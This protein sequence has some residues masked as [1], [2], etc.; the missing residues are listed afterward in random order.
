MHEMSVAQNIVDIVQEHMPDGTE[1]GVRIVRLRIGKMAGIVTDS[2]EFCF[3]VITQGT[4]LQNAQLEI[5]TEPLV[6]RCNTCTRTS[7]IDEPIFLCPECGSAE[8]KV[9]SGMELHIS[10]I[11]LY[12]M[13]T[14]GG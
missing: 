10:E 12:D 7:E 6:I 13:Q 8:V 11:E 3:E 4:P 1:T 14:E 2:L 9:E 5:H